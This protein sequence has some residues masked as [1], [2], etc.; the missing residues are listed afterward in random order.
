MAAAACDG[1]R[2]AMVARTEGQPPDR[3]GPIILLDD[4]VLGRL[5]ADDVDAEDVSVRGNHRPALRVA[6]SD[7]ELP[8]HLEHRADEAGALGG[9]HL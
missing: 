4:G 2:G 5:K 1:G 7:H 6:R 9:A 8:W 3:E